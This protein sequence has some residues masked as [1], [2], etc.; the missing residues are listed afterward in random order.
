MHIHLIRHG[1]PA[2]LPQPALSRNEYARWL[3]SYDA[4]GIMDQPPA[5][6]L[7]WLRTA[8]IGN[9]ISSSLPRAI[10]SADAVAPGRAKSD[11][12]FNEA[13]IAIPSVPF[14][15]HSTAWTSVGRILWLLGRTTGENFIDF[16]FRAQ[17]ATDALM[18]SAAVANTVLVGHG[19][20][21]RIIGKELRRRGFS[22]QQQVRHGYWSRTSFTR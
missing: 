16:R 11:P 8:K 6:L 22:L 4:M 18:A 1:R 3:I 13:A 7:D 12:L 9:L 2:C 17:A 5:S 10:Q 14:R 19:W 15:M 21:N 20:M